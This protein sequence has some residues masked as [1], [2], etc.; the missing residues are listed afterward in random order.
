MR[1]TD[2]LPLALHKGGAGVVLEHEPPT[3]DT[4]AILAPA[5]VGVVPLVLPTPAALF[6]MEMLALVVQVDCALAAV[7]PDDRLMR[8]IYFDL[9]GHVRVAG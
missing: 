3:I 1:I 8:S 5:P 4:R 9:E 7:T 2:L 6:R